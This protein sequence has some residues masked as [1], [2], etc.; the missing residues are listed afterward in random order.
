VT[1]TRVPLRVLP[2]PDHAVPAVIPPEDEGPPPDDRQL[3]IRWD[4][5]AHGVPRIGLQATATYRRAMAWSRRGPWSDEDDPDEEPQPLVRPTELAELETWVIRLVPALLEAAT[6]C[7]PTPQLMR[8]VSPP[9]Y[10][11]LVR[12][13]N[14]AVRRGRVARRP[15]RVLKVVLSEPTPAIVEAS[16]VLSDGTRARAAALRFIPV[17]NRWVADALTVG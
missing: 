6:G 4:R 9:V 12:R 8:W 15:L 11:A 14:R 3:A 7:R 17:D 10:E 13:H 1:V 2:I 5:V 16:V